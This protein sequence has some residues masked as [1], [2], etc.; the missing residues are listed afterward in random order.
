MSSLKYQLANTNES[1]QEVIRH[2]EDTEQD[3]RSVVDKVTGVNNQWDQLQT[4][5]L[6]LKNRFEFKVSP[7]RNSFRVA[8]HGSHITV[9]TSQFTHH[10]SCSTSHISHYRFHVNLFP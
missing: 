8:R 1:G 10:V 7:E 3:P 6:E 5:L 2:L 4:Q 9:H